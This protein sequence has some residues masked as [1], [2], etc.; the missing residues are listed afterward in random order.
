M[1]RISAWAKIWKIKFNADKSSDLLF[2]TKSYPT[3]PL[4]FLNSETIKKVP[5]HK[6]LG[7]YL[8][9]TLDW[10][11]QIHEVCLKA[12]HKL[13]VL[14]SIH[15]I[16]RKTLDLLYKVLVR[17]IIDY[18]LPV[19]Y[20]SL[21][22]SKKKRLSQIQYRAGKLCTGALHLT[23]QIKLEQEMGWISIEKQ[24]DF[25]S[26]CLFQK[27][28]CGHTR[29]LVR[30]CMPPRLEQ[31]EHNTRSRRIFQHLKSK[32]VVFSKSFFLI[33]T[34][35]FEQLP[36][37]CWTKSDKD[38]FKDELKLFLCPS[39]YKFLEEEQKLDV[40]SQLKYELGGHI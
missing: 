38:L 27:I 24:A 34:K 11:K 22:V 25:L 5:E 10:T 31:T 39:R 9:S 13:A 14:R 32:S 1:A 12:N 17:S 21:N 30:K 36:K 28:L 3:N 19:Y 26:L 20:H 2:S 7:I 29:P 6:H 35:K 33:M 18:A 40:S 37:S 23:S 4:L 15:Y 16:Q 8:T